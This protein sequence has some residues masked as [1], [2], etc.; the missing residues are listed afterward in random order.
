MGFQVENLSIRYGPT[1]ALHDVSLQFETGALGLLGP[2]GAGKSSLLRALLGFVQPAAGRVRV[3]GQPL[4]HNAVRLRRFIGYHPEDDVLLPGMNGVASVAL[5]GELAGLTHSDAI[6]RAHEILYFV[7]LGEVRYR[8]S[9]TY[10]QG[11]RQRLKLAQAL[12]HD[13]QLLLLDEPTNGLDPNGRREMLRLIRD[14]ATAKG[15]HLILSSHLLPD[16]EAACDQVALLDRGRLLAAGRLQDLLRQA[17]ASFEVRVKGDLA[18][19]EATLAQRGAH[20]TRTPR[21]TL[22]VQVPTRSARFVFEA[23]RDSDCQ[24]R[25]LSPERQSL[26]EM[27]A[28]TVAGGADAHS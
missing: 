3:L 5:C 2:N 10:S 12:V 28:A 1:L 25:R 19:F 17:Q 4:G 27:F 23:A 16:V 26:V 9:T 14:L 6:Q 18:R 22:L 11:M 15:V 13:P 20:S 21:G 24:V 7:G 8:L